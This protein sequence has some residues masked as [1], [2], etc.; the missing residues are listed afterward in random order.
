[1]TTYYPKLEYYLEKSR[2]TGVWMALGFPELELCPH[3]LQDWFEI[4]AGQT[5]LVLVVSTQDSPEAIELLKAN[6]GPYEDAMSWVNTD[7]GETEVFRSVAMLAEELLG[8]GMKYV[9]IE[10][11]VYY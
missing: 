5:R 4:P 3:K 11:E 1:M 8:Q 9:T 2:P 7:V 10:Y 6:V